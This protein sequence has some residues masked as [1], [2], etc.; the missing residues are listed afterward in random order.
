M[1]K[2]LRAVGMLLFVLLLTALPHAAQAK[3]VAGG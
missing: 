3:T 2:I 1:T